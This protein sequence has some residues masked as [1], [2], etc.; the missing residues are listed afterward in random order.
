MPLDMSKID[1]MARRN[2]RRYEEQI[3][4]SNHMEQTDAFIK[5]AVS[6]LESESKSESDATSVHEFHEEKPVNSKSI[7][8][9]QPV[10]TN[11]HM[12][13]DEQEQLERTI[14]EDN[15]A[16]EESEYQ[17]PSGIYK[18]GDTEY[19]YEMHTESD[20][21]DPDVPNMPVDGIPLSD[22]AD[23]DNIDN[24]D[25]KMAENTMSSE[26]IPDSQ[27][28][29]SDSIPDKTADIPDENIGRNIDRDID[30]NIK[31]NQ[32]TDSYVSESVTTPV[33][34]SVT[35]Q[36]K[37][38]DMSQTVSAMQQKPRSAVPRIPS[39]KKDTRVRKESFKRPPSIRNDPKNTIAVPSFPKGLMQE[40]RNIYRNAPNNSDALTAFVYAQLG[41][42]DLP[43]SDDIKELVK[44]GDGDNTLVNMEQRMRKLEDLMYAMN[45]LLREMELAIAYVAFDRVG[46]R[47]DT[48]NSPADINFLENGMPDAIRKLR[49]DAARKKVWDNSE[50]GRPIR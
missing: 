29:N 17:F 30:K 11:N 40:V 45:D 42:P 46:F 21:P 26:V 6:K 5:D 19:N 28:V 43:I 10:D 18:Y 32:E 20:E 36:T 22:I 2:V 48:P 27:A 4:G 3:S 38:E 39:E 47:R 33:T 16:I 44:S 41:N 34:K 7:P 24:T 35:M 50:N 15:S 9:A 8:V 1:A 12:D 31:K 14:D 25:T 23:D 37:I 13:E 49:T